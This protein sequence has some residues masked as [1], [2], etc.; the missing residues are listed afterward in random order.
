[1]GLTAAAGAGLAAAGWYAGALP[2]YIVL[3]A[4]ASGSQ[5]G[6]IAVWAVYFGRRRSTTI[7]ATAIF[8]GTIVAVMF[9]SFI[10]LLMGAGRATTIPAI[11]VLSLCLLGATLYLRVGAPRLS[12]RRTRL[13]QRRRAASWAAGR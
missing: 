4:G 2:G 6:A 1:M 7:S 8:M 11:A 5:A 10:G 13:G 12:R 9:Q 3:T